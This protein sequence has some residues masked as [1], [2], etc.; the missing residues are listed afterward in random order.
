[1]KMRQSILCRNRSIALWRVTGGIGLQIGAA[2]KARGTFGDQPKGGVLGLVKKSSANQTPRLPDKRVADR[3]PQYRSTSPLKSSTRPGSP[4]DIVLYTM[5]MPIRER[6]KLGDFAE[7]SQFNC[8]LDKRTISSSLHNYYNH[9]P[10][11]IVLGTP[12]EIR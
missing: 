4:S 5:A 10:T 12:G 9:G 6:T 11:S 7:T 8:S 2:F 1:M 3:V